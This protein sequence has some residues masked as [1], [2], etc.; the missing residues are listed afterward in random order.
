MDHI[1][2]TGDSLCE[3]FS[4]HSLKANMCTSCMK[5]ISKHRK[6]V[7]KD[8]D[9]I[10]ALECTQ[11]GERIPSLILEKD[12]GLG[13]LYLGG[14]K[15]VTNKDFVTQVNLKG[16]VNTAGNALF[17]LFGRKFKATYEGA[18]QSNSIDYLSVDWEDSLQ[19]NIPEQDLATVLRHIHKV[20]T[21]G[22]AVLVHCAQGKSRST[23]AVISYL[24]S[25]QNTTFQETL[26]F[27]QSKRKMAEP[28]PHFMKFLSRFESSELRT[29]LTKELTS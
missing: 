13:A 17:A 25:I 9:L 29:M 24:M 18:I 27:V 1:C 8:E 26:S 20:R 15:A 23:T 16:V 5:E 3:S 7:V 4:G 28:N 12:K 6:N 2:F 14:F 21:R 11:K 10:K 19:F 22:E